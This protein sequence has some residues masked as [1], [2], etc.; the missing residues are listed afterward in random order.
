MTNPAPSPD[1]PPQ[2]ETMDALVER[3]FALTK[4]GDDFPAIEA[5][6]AV[7]ARAPRFPPARVNLGI[8]ARRAGEMDVAVE[9]FRG[10]SKLEPLNTEYHDRLA[11]TQHQARMYEEA[12]TSYKRLSILNPSASEPLFNLSVVLSPVGQSDLALA[13]AGRLLVL[14]PEEAAVWLRYGRL[15]ARATPARET[16]DGIRRALMLEPDHADAMSEWAKGWRGEEDRLIWHRRAMV[17]APGHLGVLRRLSRL[18]AAIG[19]GEAAIRAYVSWYALSPSDEALRDEVLDAADRL[20]LREQLTRAGGPTRSAYEEWIDAYD[21]IDGSMVWQKLSALEPLP[22]VTVLVP[23]VSGPAAEAARQQ[24]YPADRLDIAMGGPAEAA[25]AKGDFVVCLKDEEALAPDA[26]A[27]LIERVLTPEDGCPPVAVYGDEDEIL[28][29]PSDGGAPAP[30]RRRAPRFKPDWDPVAAR[31]CDWPGGPILF[32]RAALEKISSGAE[33]AAG[34]D[35]RIRL[36]CQLGEDGPVAHVPR[37]LLH[38]RR[39]T[40]GPGVFAAAERHWKPEPP[41]SLPPVTVV[42]P[43]RNRAE[44]LRLSIDGLLTGTDYPDLEIIVVDNGSD[45]PDALAL[46]EEI[47]ADPRV[48]ILSHPGPFNFAAMN[49]RA[50]R[51]ARGEVFCLLNN[52]VEPIDRDWLKVMAGHALEPKTGLVGARLSFPDSTLQHV[53]VMLRGSVV[54]GHFDLKEPFDY[55]GHLGLDGVNRCVSAATAACL[56]LR[57]EVWEMLGGLDEE[58]FQIDFNDVDFGLRAWEAGYRVIVTPDARLTHHE[59]ATRGTFVSKQKSVRHLAERDAMVERWGDALSRDRF[60]NP[61]LAIDPHADLFSLAFPPRHGTRYAPLSYKMSAPTVRGAPAKAMA[62]CAI[63]RDEGRHLE[64]WLQFHHI[65]GAEHFYLYDNESADDPLSVLDPWIR[66]GKVTYRRMPGRRQQLPAY[67]DC[68]RRHREEARWIGFLDLD[69]FLFAPEIPDLREA[70]SRYEDA[71]GVGVNWTM[72]GSSGHVSPPTG[73]T[74]ASYQLRAP[75]DLIFE[76]AGPGTDSRGGSPEPTVR[77]HVARHIKSIVDPAATRSVVSPHAFVYEEQRLA[78]TPAGATIGARPGISVSGSYC[79]GPLRLNHYWSRSLEEFDAKLLRGR[80]DTGR[81][82]E[83]ERARR[84]EKRMNAI[85]DTAI[86][87]HAERTAARMGLPFEPGTA[88]DWQARAAALTDGS[89]P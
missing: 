14:I 81:T 21:R 23:S 40:V 58:R 55:P 27:L 15:A 77:P 24:I 32:R 88:A 82:R 80:A 87:A 5:W 37:I 43:T 56:V 19:S 22:E 57:R 9:A 2:E 34:D 48:R 76:G 69:E 67:A 60:H 61:N 41:T 44:L 83:A 31:E 26:V 13:V 89:E 29:L 59:S 42:I 47:A 79:E 62:L 6:K 54:A 38:R 10:V 3:A 53:G 51:E 50:F 74:T 70:M 85:H 68:L 66:D 63:F 84:Q 46:L 11:A 71:P 75:I 16:R 18:E 72:F 39:S 25:A 45:E 73:L 78:V 64:E 12:A 33:P 28:C 20:G 36:L 86:L 30:T 8:V 7:V 4:A 52:D 1:A 65:H 17:L 49:N 35:P